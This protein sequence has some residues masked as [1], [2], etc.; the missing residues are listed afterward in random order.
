MTDFQTATLAIL[1]AALAV[2]QTVLALQ[3]AELEVSRSVIRAGI[4]Q[5][6]AGVLQ[7]LVIAGGLLFMRS[8]SRAR[9][10]EHARRHEETMAAIQERHEATMA[11]L[12]R[13]AK[14]DAQHAEAVTAL[15]TLIERTSTPRCFLL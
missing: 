3:E 4:G 9:A 15:N 7:T 10:Q 11:M 13:D 8:E 12:R 5:I 2:Q 14:P 1:E 6:M